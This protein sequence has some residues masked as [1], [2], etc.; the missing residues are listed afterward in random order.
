MGLE[1]EFES[2]LYD[3]PPAKDLLVRLLKARRI[4]PTEQRVALARLVFSRRWHFAAEDLGELA[5]GS[6]FAVSMPTVY[7]TLNLFVRKGLLKELVVDPRRT[8]YDSNI[9]E[10][11]HIWDARTG[12][13][14]D[15]DM[16]AV[17]VRDAGKWGL[18][19]VETCDV[20]VRIRR[21]S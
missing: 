1:E 9:Q 14:V 18:E 10:H 2:G 13:I 4:R 20:L 6:G 19:G 8:L 12:S 15:V 7:S 21:S 17:T 11:C 5:K 3:G 16:G